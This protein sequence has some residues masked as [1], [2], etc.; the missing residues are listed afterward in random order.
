VALSSR[1]IEQPDAVN[2]ATARTNVELATDGSRITDFAICGHYHCAL[3]YFN[4]HFFSGPA[5]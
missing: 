1:T 3:T 5:A 4:L 2:E